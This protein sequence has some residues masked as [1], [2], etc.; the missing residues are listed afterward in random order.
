MRGLFGD[1]GRARSW[2]RRIFA[3]LAV[4]AGLATVP[5]FAHSNAN[6]AFGPFFF[7]FWG[8]DS[9][10]S[11]HHHG[12]G[13]NGPVVKTAEGPVSGYTENGVN[14]FLGIPYAAPPVG[15]LR[16]RP[17]QPVQKWRS[18]LDAT[19]FGP[20]CPQVTE[21]GAFAGPTSI[22]ED[23]LYLNVFTTGKART[24]K[25]VIVWIYGG[26]N[27]DGESNDYDGSKLATG[28]PLGQDT[29]VVSMNY[30]IGIL[31]FFSNPAIN[32][33]GHL[34]VNYGILDQQA[35]LKW[36]QRNI[37]SFGGDPNNV[38]LGGQSAG[39]YDTQANLISPY[40]KGLFHRAILQSYPGTTWLTAATTLTRGTNFGVAAGCPGSDA[41]AAKCLRSLSAA[42]VLQ[43]QGTPNTTTP[44][45]AQVTVDGNVIPRQ[46]DD[47][48]KSG[49]F[50]KMPI[51][52][53]NV[54]D[55]GNFSVGINEY[56]SSPQA[57]MSEAQYTAAVT[58][59]ALDQYPLSS[60]GSPAL[61]YSAYGSDST[62]CLTL[63]VVKELASLVP[64]YAYEFN[65]QKAPYHFPQMPGYT[66]LATH[67]IDIQFLFPGYHGGILGVNLDQATGQP[68]EIG[69][70]EVTLSD[71]LVAAWTNFAK[72]GNPNGSSNSPWPLFTAGAQ[73]FFSQNV[74]SS[75]VLSADAYAADHKCAYWNPVRGY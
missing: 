32:S 7:P 10:Y 68:R 71:Q 14:I 25:P 21:L 66:P 20:T 29:V 38:T 24:K 47:A 26:A 28:G 65:Y 67:T 18:T 12:S 51:M 52:T 35:V 6:F 16:W 63:H 58:G 70:D 4:V 1:P 39:S 60:Y 44:Y 23:C 41:A 13:G 57:P 5:A 40:A 75:T 50:N 2:G 74:P 61:A 8:H 59:A 37:A 31:G 46:P 69:G 33:E 62:A 45:L 64:V 54:H 19:E 53:G 36:V 22:N 43:L 15:N 9:N 3:S 11:G 34:A 48:W 72:T 55:E 17:P 49:N 42:R 30:R 73:N 27:E 56:F